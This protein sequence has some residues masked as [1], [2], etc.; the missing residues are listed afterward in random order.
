MQYKRIA[1]RLQKSELACR[2]HYHQLTKHRPSIDIAMYDSDGFDATGITATP[3]A[4]PSCS[5]NITVTPPTTHEGMEHLKLPSLTAML[6]ESCHRRRIS[7]PGNLT[8]PVN[9][10]QPQLT[11]PSYILPPPR[12]LLS[13][14]DE[15]KISQVNSGSQRYQ[16][17]APNDPYGHGGHHRSHSFQDH[18]P[19]RP[20]TMTSY[21]NTPR[22]SSPM[23]TSMAA[24]DRCSVNALLNHHG[25][26]TI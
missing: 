23:C 20:S 1:A 17:P 14:F 18:I 12:R 22:Y 10:S 6:D 15:T 7:L 2:L 26:F 21:F 16:L 5:S 11:P 19:N 4:S 25:S 8:V 13:P 9:Q 3:R 24:G